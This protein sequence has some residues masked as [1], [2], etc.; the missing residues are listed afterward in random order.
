MGSP[1]FGLGTEDRLEHI[2]GAAAIDHLI[3]REPLQFL[4]LTACEV[5]QFHLQSL[6]VPFPQ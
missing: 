4:T 6:L 1:D 3:A 2:H 5:V